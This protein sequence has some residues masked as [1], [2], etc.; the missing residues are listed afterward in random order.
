MLIASVL[1]AP[2]LLASVRRAVHRRW[3]RCPD[4]GFQIAPMGV[5]DRPDGGSDGVSDALF[6]V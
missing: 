3:L 1:I 5:P 6:G 2:L 4:G